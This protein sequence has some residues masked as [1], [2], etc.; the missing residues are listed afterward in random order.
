ML[1]QV[2]WVQIAL[3]DHDYMNT[4]NNKYQYKI[5][6]THWRNISVPLIQLDHIS[7]G[8]YHI[9]YRKSVDGRAW[10]TP[11]DITFDVKA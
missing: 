8:R 7:S 10:S 2:S 6:N 1:D 11:I 4:A 3:T 5:N 9:Q